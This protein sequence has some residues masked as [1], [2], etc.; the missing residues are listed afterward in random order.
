MSEPGASAVCIPWPYSAMMQC[1]AWPCSTVP[2]HIADATASR[3]TLRR[4]AK[5]SGTGGC[6]GARGDRRGARSDPGATLVRR[7]D[8]ADGLDARDLGRG[9]ILSKPCRTDSIS[10]TWF[11]PGRSGTSSTVSARGAVDLRSSDASQSTWSA[12]CGHP[13]HSRSVLCA[14]CLGLCRESEGVRPK[15]VLDVMTEALDS[16][17]K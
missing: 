9:T 15:A 16:I 7:S 8:L 6:R 5:R 14:L 11:T 2:P 12:S 4:I 13:R 10:R 1:K 17:A 3:V